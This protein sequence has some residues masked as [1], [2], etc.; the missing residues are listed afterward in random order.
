MIENA[1]YVI[2]ARALWLSHLAKISHSHVMFNQTDYELNRSEN[3]NK[4][5]CREVEKKRVIIKI[6]RYTR[7]H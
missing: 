7:T 6:N 2:G 5:N 3:K 1:F 4:L